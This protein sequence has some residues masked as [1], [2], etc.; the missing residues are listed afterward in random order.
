MSAI[1]D[2]KSKYLALRQR[3]Q[4]DVEV[5]FRLGYEQG[6]QDS[7]MQQMQDQQQQ[8]VDQQ[9]QQAQMEANGMGGDAGQENQDPNAQ[10][11]QV[12]DDSRGVG[13][14]TG[15]AGAPQGMNGTQL[16]SHIGELEGLMAKTDYGTDQWE[17]LKKSID[18]LKSIKVTLDLNKNAVLIKNIASN[19]RKST[20][21][22]GRAKHNL[23][24]A[25]K[26][27]ISM[28]HKIVSE[29]MDTWSKEEKGLP[30]EISKIL[31]A[32]GLSKKE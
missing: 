9:A 5:S 28:Q 1:V 29:L 24:P 6:T 21:I 14:Q 15:A 16:D 17:T 22:G 27:A 31:Q 25:A 23:A 3:Y 11:A 19:L 20:V 30:T 4:E 2:Y 32:E 7:Q 26:T 18:N 12:Q 8:L 10:G 13:Q